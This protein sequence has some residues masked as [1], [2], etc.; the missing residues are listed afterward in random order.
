M[1]KKTDEEQMGNLLVLYMKYWRPFGELL[2][3]LE[4]TGFIIDT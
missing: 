3:D 2:T 1:D 4:R